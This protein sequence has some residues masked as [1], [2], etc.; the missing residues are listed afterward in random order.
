[1]VHRVVVQ[2]LLHL[3]DRLLISQLAIHETA[4]TRLLHHLGPVVAGDLAEALAAVDYRVVD[5]LRVGQQEAAISCS[6]RW[7]QVRQ[8][9]VMGWR[10]Q[11]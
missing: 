2:N 7:S 6:G 10:R 4:A 8:L 3:A 1:M 5:Y 11:D 9:V